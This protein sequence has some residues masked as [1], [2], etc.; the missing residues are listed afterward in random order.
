MS[1]P[2]K[3]D[4]SSTDLCQSKD[5]STSNALSNTLD[6]DDTPTSA[7]SPGRWSEAKPFENDASQKLSEIAGASTHASPKPSSDQNYIIAV[8]RYR[9]D[10]NWSNTISTKE[11]WIKLSFSKTPVGDKDGRSFCQ[12]QIGMRGGRRLQSNCVENCIIG[13]DVDTGATMD[14]V[15]AIVEERGLNYIAYHTHSHLKPFSQVTEKKVEQ[16]FQNVGKKFEDASDEDIKNLI[17]QYLR[18][19]KRVKQVVLDSVS[20]IKREMDDGVVYKLHHNPMHRVRLIV[21]LREPFDFMD[22]PSQAGR[23]K[24]WKAAYHKAAHVLGVPIDESCMDPSRLFYCPRRPEGSNADLFE[25]RNKIDGLDLDLDAICDEA[26]RDPSYEPPVKARRERSKTQR[27][28]H[29]HLDPKL[30]KFA[31]QYGERLLIADWLEGEYPE[32][33]RSSHTGE[34]IEFRCP[35]AHAHSDGDIETDR[36]FFVKNGGGE[37]SGDGFVCACQ[38]ATCKTESGNDRLFFL[39]LLLK[40]L[41]VDLRYLKERYVEDWDE[42]EE[43]SSDFVSSENQRQLNILHDRGE[44]EKLQQDLLLRIGSLDKNS[45]ELK[46]GGIKALDPL[47]DD[48]ALVMQSETEIGSYVAEICAAIKQ[49]WKHDLKRELKLR[50]KNAQQLLHAANSKASGADWL[51][52]GYLVR[53]NRILKFQLSDGQ[54]GDCIQVCGLFHVTGQCTDEA[55]C[56]H[57]IEVT[58]ECDG[59]EKCVVIEKI[60]LAGD[61]RILREKLMDSGLF[62]STQAAARNAFNDLLNTLHSDVQITNA[63]KPGWHAD[64]Q[65]FITPIGEAIGAEVDK[66]WRLNERARPKNVDKKGTLEAW[67]R[68]V[69]EK[70]SHRDTPHFDL[71]LT[72]ACAG[73][74]LQLIDEPSCGLGLIGPSSKGKSLAQKISTSVWGSPRPDETV[75]LTCRATDNALEFKA[76]RGNGSVLHLDEAKTGNAK[77]ITLLPFLLASGSGKSRMRADGSERIT[78]TWNTFFTYSSERPLEHYATQ[79][80][81]SVV[82]GSTVRCPEVDVSDLTSLPNPADAKTVGDAAEAN[83]GHAGPLFVSF[84]MN[85]GYHHN[86]ELIREKIDAAEQLLLQGDKRATVQRA[87]RVFASLWVAGDLM[88]EAGL[89]T[90]S[91]AP[92]VEWA[93]SSY[94]NSAA[95]QNLDGAARSVDQLIGWLVHNPSRIGKAS[96][97]P[98]DCQSYQEILAWRRGPIIF[99]P[100]NS[101][102]KISAITTTERALVDEL[103]RRNMLQRQGK[104]RAHT[105]IPTVGKIKHYR[106]DLTGHLDGL[107]DGLESGDDHEKNPTLSPDLKHSDAKNCGR[108]GEV[109]LGLKFPDHLVSDSRRFVKYD[110]KKFDGK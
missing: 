79:L 91:T 96:D 85:K 8:G 102:E 82:T 42:A 45:V 107:D 74:L 19:V 89:I 56:G 40:E 84:L 104:N 47:L 21:F 61:G 62:V 12:G 35:N 59:E 58:F 77:L 94:L 27:V 80:R 57:G 52:A 95:S 97:Y 93:L 65:I 51:P 67:K 90:H 6:C 48:V 25:I 24:A 72:M 38:H 81:E 60:H 39:D 49:S 31:A 92:A 7:R 101:I 69:A 18:D 50:F 17:V 10:Q 2:T 63:S 71:A 15:C 3:S 54:P 106:I 100:T 83:F 32:D 109:Q 23:C 28:N 68:D 37:G 36:A 1:R 5:Q 43:T 75:L 108:E 64:N 98:N 11:K 88:Q 4:N 78:L 105:R 46:N 53:G 87:A 110:S 44:R 76:A 103:E 14:E 29:V 22:P 16:L 99:L 9:R 20:H 86:P 41:A 34:K 33:C 73:T 70:C 13:F 26:D 55:G 30:I 66:V